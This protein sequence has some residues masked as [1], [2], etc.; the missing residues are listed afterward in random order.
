M[1]FCSAFEPLKL[2]GIKSNKHTLD[3]EKEN[4]PASYRRKKE[5]NR[6]HRV[7]SVFVVILFLFPYSSYFSFRPVAIQFNRVDGAR[8]HAHLPM[9][10]CVSFVYCYNQCQSVCAFEHLHAISIFENV[11]F[12]LFSIFN[13]INSVLILQT[14]VAVTLNVYELG[15]F[16]RLFLWAFGFCLRH[17]KQLKAMLIMVETASN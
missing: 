8:A 10:L 1:C 9:R 15:C 11:L 7:D 14:G 12:P 5:Y 17:A 16:Q 4:W 2:S 3:E 13:R 6:L